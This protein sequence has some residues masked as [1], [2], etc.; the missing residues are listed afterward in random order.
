MSRLELDL[1]PRCSI[2]PNTNR[3]VRGDGP[4]NVK[5]VCIGEEPG[6]EEDEGGRPFVGAAG[7]EFNQNY[8]RLA[9]LVR[10]IYEE[11]DSD[12]YVTNA[13]KCRQH[14][15]KT[16]TYNEMIGCA[17][18]FI[19]TELRVINPTYVILMG[20]VPCR[21]LGER[22]VDL[23]SEHGIPRWGRIYD[24][25]GWIIPIN[26]PAAGLH[27]GSMMT[28]MLEDWE[29]LGEWFRT[30]EW[31]WAEDNVESRDYRLC[32]T[33][34]EIDRYFQ[35]HGESKVLGILWPEL[36]LLGLDTETHA[37]QR[38]SIQVSSRVGTGMMIQT[39]D[40]KFDLALLEI[41]RYWIKKLRYELALHNAEADLWAAELMGLGNIPYRDTMQ[42][43]YQFQNMPQKLK[44]ISR[45]VLG[46][47]RTS[48][49][50]L[51][52]PYSKAVLLDWMGQGI[53]HAEEHWQLVEERKHKKTGKALKPKITK[54][55]VER[56]LM[57]VYNHAMSNPEYPSDMTLWQKLDERLGQQWADRLVLALG[58]RPERG[59]AH[60][61][62][63]EAIDYG[64][65][66]AD[67]TLASALM[68]ELMRKEFKK[69]VAVTDEDK[70]KVISPFPYEL[71][72]IT[73]QW[74]YQTQV[75]RQA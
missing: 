39:D 18:H 34:S 8:L 56:T 60:V 41:L 36:R 22:G 72:D 4:I 58:A 27:D 12:V 17:N 61:P 25:E 46:R 48:W 51:V 70:D 57:D 10:N 71:R 14:Q 23:E 49:E 73:S 16:P 13:R 1:L 15:N 3:C 45:R 50:E 35:D 67:D 28:P 44:A 38:W 32:R 26:H 68:F 37:G 42:E 30:G 6:R 24:W 7:K 2:C 63:A 53:L 47:I 29:K 64:C 52:T 31:Q 33:V 75:W 62:L 55:V 11:T 69:K 5:V 20:A 21:L 59:I 43:A 54:S 40:G 65:S 66:D 74:T 19:P 9:G